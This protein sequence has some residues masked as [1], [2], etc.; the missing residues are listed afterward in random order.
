MGTTY[1][2]KF[3]PV[4]S[5]SPKEISQK[6]EDILESFNLVC[7]TYIPSSEIS[8]INQPKVFNGLVS[9]E[10]K[11]LFLSGVSLNKKT[12]GSFDP[13]IGP[14]VNL[15]GFGPNKLKKV[16]TKKEVRQTKLLAGLQH[17]SLEQSSFIK[18]VPK[19]YLDFSAF[20]K[21]RGVDIVFEYLQGIGAKEVFVEI[22]GEIR[23]F[24]NNKTWRL[25]IESPEGSNNKSNAMKIV[26][27]KK[28]SLA[29]SGDY[30]NFYI[31]KRGDKIS[32][33]I[34]LLSGHPKENLTASV[35]VFRKSDCISA[36]AWATALMVSDFKKALELSEAEGIAAYFIYKENVKDSKY[37]VHKT[38]AWINTFEKGNTP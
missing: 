16:P 30:R 34:N 6:I 31:D 29:T 14:L 15:W 9:Q 18:K 32:H 38:S 12:Q 1:K 33:G 11:A 10:F 2:V 5:Y 17:Y 4:S 13:T 25:G 7:S 8:K 27:I 3:S 24:G 37:M 22:G 19:A 20:A 36:D 26:S 23:V 35:T 28:G 21:G